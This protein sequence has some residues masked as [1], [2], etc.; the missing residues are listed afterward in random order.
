MATNSEKLPVLKAR[1]QA[2]RNR[3]EW[4]LTSTET[5]PTQTNPIRDAANDAIASEAIGLL[6]GKL[7][8]QRRVGR[9]VGRMLSV[10]NR[11]AKRQAQRSQCRST[12]LAMLNE[13]DGLLETISDGMAPRTMSSLRTSVRQARS[14][15]G[16]APMLRSCIAVASRIESLEP[17]RPKATSPGPGIDY[18]RLKGLE[19]ALRE[20]IQGRL[21]RMAPNWWESRIPA[22]VRTNAERRVQVRDRKW[23][24][25]DA[26]SSALI[27][28]LDFSDYAKVIIDPSNWNEV[29]RPVF[30]DGQVV[31]VK[32]LELEPIRNDVAHS[33]DLSTLNREKLRIYS[34][35]L[36]KLVGR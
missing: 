11:Q 27:D 10:Q 31:R 9:K 19:Q 1:A 29:F 16:G 8:G 15:K 18:V 33:R 6:T 24:W 32:L 35:E 20:L 5:S 25:H 21:G 26:N 23:P 7:F 14:L 17:P 28:Y 13:L 4:L 34:G 22:E 12:A 3:A 30:G 2:L 36:L